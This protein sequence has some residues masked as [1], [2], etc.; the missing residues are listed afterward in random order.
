MNSRLTVIFFI[1]CSVCSCAQD[2]NMKSRTLEDYYTPTGVEKYFLSDIPNW[3]NFDQ[4]AGCFRETNIR[5]FDINALMKSYALTYNQALQVQAS[6][7]EE[8]NRF[9]KLDSTRETNLKEEEL[10]FYKVSEKISSK[11]LFFDPPIFKRINL[12][13][14]DEVVG[15]KKKERKL[16]VLLKSS[17]MEL[18]VPVLVS[19]CMTRSEVEKKFPNLNTKMITAELFTV[20]DSLGRTMPGFK[21]DLEQFFNPDQKLFIYVQK[22]LVPEEAFKGTVKIINY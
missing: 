14:L 13:W 16:E 17:D 21:F 18:G 10:L 6:F 7:N 9:K 1:I 12:I 3:A 22:N 8:F 11:I 19:F 2:R 15:D 5:Y 4:K 20:Y